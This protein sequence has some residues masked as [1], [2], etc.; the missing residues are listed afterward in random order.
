M[1]RQ[2]SAVTIAMPP[3]LAIDL[4][5]RP[6]GSGK[7]TVS[8]DARQRCAPTTAPSARRRV[9]HLLH[10]HLGRRGAGGEA[11]ARACRRTIRRCRSAGGVD[12]V[13]RRA[14]ALGQLAQAVAVGAG[15]AAD[16]D[17]HVDLR[18]QQLD[19]VLPVLRGVADVLL[20]GLA[21][22]REARACTAAR[23][24]AA[25]STDSVV[26]VTRR[27]CRSA[28]RCTRATSCDVFDQVDAARSAG[29]SCL[30]PRG[31]PCGRS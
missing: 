18:R 12:H 13:G 16:H 1:Q 15:R 21:H 9:D 26:C 31:G 11:D 17:H 3:R 20:L 25:S 24:S 14:Q 7:C 8:C 28:R 23:I 6:F 2:I 4:S 10:Q 27:A 30:R 29:P 19:R 5:P 22:V